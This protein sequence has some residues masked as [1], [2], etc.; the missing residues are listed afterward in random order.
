M[1]DSP[2]ELMFTI[3]VFLIVAFPIGALIFF[4][5]SDRKKSV[6]RRPSTAPPQP[7]PQANASSTQPMPKSSSTVSS[8]PTLL[9][10]AACL[11]LVGWIC[12]AL[13]AIELILLLGIVFISVGQQSPF[14]GAISA[15]ILLPLTITAFVI[16]LLCVAVA[17]L[18][19]LFVDIALNT[20]S[21][22]KAV[23]R[24]AES[25]SSS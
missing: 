9:F 14:L 15:P 5:I 7:F 18:T 16:G 3:V 23:Q 19:S 12:V 17:E 25:K 11:R 24:L 22:L 10:I 21:L 6:T 4:V 2:F 20:A 13:G 1:G 8:Y